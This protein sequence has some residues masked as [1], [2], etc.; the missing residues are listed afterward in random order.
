MFP[1]QYKILPCILQARE[2]AV[3]LY[4]KML[5]G[6]NTF[7][8]SEEAQ[9]QKLSTWFSCQQALTFKLSFSSLLFP[10]VEKLKPQFSG[11]RIC[12]IFKFS[13]SHENEFQETANEF[14]TTFYFTT[15]W[16]SPSLCF[17]RFQNNVDP[18]LYSVSTRRVSMSHPHGTHKDH[19]Q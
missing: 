7:W 8:N 13:Y 5:P 16:T 18:E 11:E 15:L 17:I 3:L 6:S 12:Y 9:E 4:N 14:Q 10:N 1:Q 2:K 19:P